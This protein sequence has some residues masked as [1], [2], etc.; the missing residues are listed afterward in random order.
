M[1]PELDLFVK[2]PVQTSILATHEIAYKPIA[3]IQNSTVLEFISLGYG[4]TYRDLSSVYLKLV[5]KIKKS[6]TEDHTDAKTGVVNNLLH[7]LFKQCSIYLNNTSISQ[8][9]NNYGYRAYFETL[10]NYGN[11]AVTTHMESCGWF[12]DTPGV[13]DDLTDKK[14]L[15]LDRRKEVFGK[16]NTVEIIGRVHADMFNQG[17]LLLNNVDLRI[18]FSFEKPEFYIM[19][20]DK[21]T[22]L[23]SIEDATLF[24]NHVTL[25]PG[26][27]LAHEA[28]LNQK[29][30]HYPYK[31]I[32]VKSYTV[33]AKNSSISLDNAVIGSLPNFIMFAM[34]DN[35]AYTGKRTLNPFNFQHFNITNF[36]LTVNGNAV[37]A[38]PITFFFSK[39]AVI[40]TRGYNHLFKSS[41]I[42]WADKGLLYAQSKMCKIFTI[43]I[44]FFIFTGNQITKIFFNNGAFM[45]G[46][47]LTNDNSYTSGC[48]NLLNQGSVRIEARFAVELPKTVTCLVYC[49]YDAAIEIDKNRNI[50]T[51]Y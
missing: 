31:R 2:P 9:D 27:L 29:N 33:P 35:L 14:N 30:A 21:G 13:L 6:A 47:D 7:S 51:S 12:L 41:G 28:V 25:N 32:E 5:L 36:Y 4:D 39:P 1:K 44:L 50:F 42:N 15:G 23:V 48:S 11:D 20:D 24:I 38:T 34:V 8:N 18:A 45:L 22:S 10:L 17:K 49:E 46:F 16:S 40:S 3:S 26:I 43:I 37:P 19:E